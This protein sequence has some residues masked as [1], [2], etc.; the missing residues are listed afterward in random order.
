MLA[1]IIVLSIKAARLHRPIVRTNPRFSSATRRTQFARCCRGALQRVPAALAAH[2][3]THPR[4]RAPAYHASLRRRG[5]A[6]L[7]P[8]LPRSQIL[9]WFPPLL[10]FAYRH[11][12]KLRSLSAKFPQVISHRGS[13]RRVLDHRPERPPLP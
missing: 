6:P 4:K 11:A 7:R 1:P 10:Q 3:F 2:H 13:R 5:A 12:V 9:A 8:S